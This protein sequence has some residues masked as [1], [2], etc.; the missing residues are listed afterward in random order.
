MKLITEFAILMFAAATTRAQLISTRT[1]N[2]SGSTASAGGIVLEWSVGEMVAIQTLTAPN[3]ILTQGLLQPGASSGAPLPVTLLFFNGKS[4]NNQT[5][6]SW[7]TSQEINNHHFDV[8]RS[9][10]GV[11]FQ[12]LGQVP[13][14]ANSPVAKTYSFTDPGPYPDTYYRLKQVDVDGNYSY[15]TIIKVQLPQ[16]LTHRIYP[17]P[18]K[19]PLYLSLAGNP[20]IAEVVVMDMNGR[21]MLRKVVNATNW[22]ELDVSHLPR[23]SYFI[24]VQRSGTVWSCKFVKH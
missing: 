23:G 6:L 19:G 8:E 17:N 2:S 16:L 11:H 1:I 15:S 22:I 9:L 18:T 10:N 24:S 20:Q 5:V 13:G 12:V 3:V 14:A 7:T 4:V 21:I